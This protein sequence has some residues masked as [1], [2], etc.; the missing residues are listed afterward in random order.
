MTPE[1]MKEKLAA[2]E[3]EFKQ[4]ESHLYRLDGIRAFLKQELEA[5]AE[6]V[7]PK[8]DPTQDPPKE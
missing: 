1:K 5:L 2:V 3:A 8:P 4:I 7:G 6:A